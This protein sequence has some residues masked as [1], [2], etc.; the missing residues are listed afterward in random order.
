MS[1]RTTAMSACASRHRFRLHLIAVPTA[2]GFHGVFGD[3][4]CRSNYGIT[5]SVAPQGGDALPLDFVHDATPPEGKKK[6]PHYPKDSEG[7]AGNQKSVVYS[8]F[9]R[10]SCFLR[11]CSSADCTACG[12]VNP[13]RPAFSA[14]DRH[15]FAILSPCKRSHKYVIIRSTLACS[16]YCIMGKSC[17]ARKALF[18]WQRGV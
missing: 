18:H 12:T 2:I 3:A 7:V 4:K 6:G 8:T 5:V 16:R 17:I 15:S 14:M 10:G 9:S 11:I 13:M 1:H